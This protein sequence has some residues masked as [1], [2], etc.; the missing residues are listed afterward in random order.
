MSPRLL[1]RV[2]LVRLGFLLGRL[3]GRPRPRVVLATSHAAAISGNLALIRDELARRRPPI[4]TRVIAFAPTASVHGLARA[5]VASI[6]SGYHLAAS[7]LFVVDDYFLPIYAIRP[8]PGTQR[9]QVWHASGA[10]KRFGYSVLDRTFGQTEADVATFPIHTNYDRCLVS[11]M[12]FAPAYAEAFHQPL[13]V[14]DASIG[15]PRTD[16]LLGPGRDAA[17]QAVRDRYPGIKGKRVV[18]YAPTFR[19]DSAIVAREPVD[20]DLRTLQERLGHDHVVLLRQHPFVRR[21]NP[22]PADLEAFVVDA[23]DDPDIHQL[24]LVSDVLVTDYSSAIY[25]FSLLGRPMAFFA[26]DLEAYERE[27]GFYFDYRSGVP[28]PVF[29]T[30]ADL[31]AWLAAGAFDLDRVARFRAESFD[32]ADGRATE[33]F[34]DDVVVP[35]LR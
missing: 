21:A 32:V 10:F 23:S 17:A 24:M 2:A 1:A 3:S 11:S 28:G 20:L 34:V 25:E 22:T 13:E 18:L 15:I 12:R 8:R 9:I 14:F 31:A 7:C 26:P 4:P 30:T 19:G 33:R 16:T 6:R 29:D 27:R 35:A 5:A